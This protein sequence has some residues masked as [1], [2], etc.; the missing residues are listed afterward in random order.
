MAAVSRPSRRQAASQ[1]DWD[2][3]KALLHLLT[4]L[5]LGEDSKLVPIYIGDD[6]TDEDAFKA[7]R[8]RPMGGTGILVSSKVGP[9]AFPPLQQSLKVRRSCRHV[10]LMPVWQ[11]HM[12]HRLA[13]LW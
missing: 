8:S 9:S 13:G 11:C 12:R 10:L 7:L 6:R 1:V 4:A 5:G 3:G 2:K